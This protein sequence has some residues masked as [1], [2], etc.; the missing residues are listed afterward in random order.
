M[1]RQLR[2][3][4]GQ[5]GGGVLV[6]A[7]Q[8]RLDV[9]GAGEFGTPGHQIV[10][11]QPQPGVTQ[12]GLDG[13]CATGHLGLAAQRLELAAQFGGEV[14]QPGH[15]GGRGIQLAQRLFLALAVLEH[16]GGFLDESPAVLRAG[17]QDLRQPALADDDVHLPADTG[18]T[19]QLLD[20]EQP[21]TVAVDLV[22][23]G[24]VAEHPAGDGY[25]GVFDRQGVI[26]VVDGQR[27]LGAAQRGPRGRAGEDD[28]L[29]LAA[30]QGFG[31]LLAHHPGQSVDDIGLAGAVRTDHTGDARLEAQSR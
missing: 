24:S 30:A 14:G 27:D 2:G 22:L 15:V 13:L 18:V 29:H 21:A 28:V 7:A 16:P 26:G 9:I 10:S 20:V 8:A 17:F 12:V 3:R 31:P 5:S 23:A 6:L 11:G 19:E 1:G 4:L 25:L